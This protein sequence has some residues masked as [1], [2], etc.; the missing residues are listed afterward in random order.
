MQSLYLTVTFVQIISD[1]LDNSKNEMQSAVFL[2][3]GKVEEGVSPFVPF[4]AVTSQY[5]GNLSVIISP[6]DVVIVTCVH[7]LASSTY[8][9][10]FVIDKR[11]PMILFPPTKDM[12][13]T[14]T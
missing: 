13:K 6:W 1:L 14:K 3:T 11:V 7:I 8:F 4:H 5:S 9:L 10:V 12:H 2:L